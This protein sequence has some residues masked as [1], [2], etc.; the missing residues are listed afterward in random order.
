MKQVIYYK[1]RVKSNKDNIGKFIFGFF[2][3]FDSYN[4]DVYKDYK[5]L[6]L[7]FAA[8]RGNGLRRSVVIHPLSDDIYSRWIFR[9]V[10]SRIITKLNKLRYGDRCPC[11]C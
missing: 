8:S 2:N 10:D 4:Y 11:K 1:P 9:S 7:C 6:Y 5:N 3:E